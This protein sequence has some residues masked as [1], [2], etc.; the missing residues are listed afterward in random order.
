MTPEVQ[1][2]AIAEACGWTWRL[3]P[4]TKDGPDNPYGEFQYTWWTNP[5]GEEKGVPPNYPADLNAMRE[6]ALT[7]P[8]TQR[9]IM[10]GFL[11]KM[12]GCMMETAFLSSSQHAEAF[13][14]TIGKWKD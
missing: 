11:Y 12:G 7:L 8:L 5:K 14:R 1:R 13:L 3:V 4:A 2:I 6:A 10:F 9:T